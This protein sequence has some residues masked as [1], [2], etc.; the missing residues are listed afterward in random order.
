MTETTGAPGGGGIVVIGGGISGITTAVEA[1]EAGHDV[2]LL[3]KEPYLGGRV[4][5]MNQYFPKLCPPT[6]GIE[7]N[8]KRIK[9]SQ[10]IKVITQA[11]VTGV[12]GEPGAYRVLVK[13]HPRR[14]NDRCTACDKCVPACPVERPDDFNYGLGTTRATYDAINLQEEARNMELS[15][16][17]VVV[18]TGWR[19]YDATRLENLGFGLLPDVI[20]NTMMERLAAKNGPTGGE[21]LRPSD[22]GPVRRVAFVQCAGSRDEN[23]LP[24]CSSVCCTASF[25]Q[26]TYVRERYPESEIHI[27]YIDIRTMGVLEDF[28]AKVMQDDEKIHLHKGKV[29]RIDRSERGQLVVTSEEIV[30]GERH[31]MV[32]DLAVLA[33]GMQPTG[34]LGTSVPYDAN[35]FVT[36]G[37]DGGVLGVGCAKLPVDVVSSVRDATAGVLHAIQSIVTTST[38]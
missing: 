12:E 3:E 28:Y 27:F 33:T 26:A 10:R 11:E 20:T 29:A 16:A 5:R 14:V 37:G 18:A 15:A 38:R 1:A 21:I 30:S 9:Q 4:V 23:H 19:P 31:E 24:Y 35:S 2:I 17:S 34:R 13:L 36:P 7:I 8:L 22:G 6:C 32:V 25:K